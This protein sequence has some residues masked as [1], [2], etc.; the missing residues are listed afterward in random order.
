M[1]YP[2][3]SFTSPNVEKEKSFLQLKFLL[4]INIGPIGACC[5]N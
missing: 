4:M 2:F 1:I 5:V 3:L